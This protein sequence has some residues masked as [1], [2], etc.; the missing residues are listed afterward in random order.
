MSLSC[1]IFGFLYFGSIFTTWRV[2]KSKDILFCFAFAFLIEESPWHMCST[3]ILMFTRK[4]M[5][6]HNL[7]CF[8]FSI[9]SSQKHVPCHFI[10]RRI[11]AGTTGK[12]ASAKKSLG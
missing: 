1:G 4:E 2:K 3:F 7:F 11:Q 12:A 10:R 8:A 6:S 5:L 9:K